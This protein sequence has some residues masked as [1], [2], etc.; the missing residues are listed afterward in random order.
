M[1][2]IGFGGKSK[3]KATQVS[4]PKAF[5]LP[6]QEAAAQEMLG[7][8]QR[9]WRGD[10]TSPLARAYQTAMSES[11][12][13]AAS[14][15]RARLAEERGISTPARQ[16][17]AASI[18]ESAVRSIAEVPTMLTQMSHEYLARYT[19]TPPQIGQEMRGKETGK[20]GPSSSLGCCFIF[21]E[22][23]RLERA[24]MDYRDLHFSPSS[25]VAVGYK[26]MSNWLIPLMR[27]YNSV[28]FAVRMLMIEP[29]T[30]YARWF[31]DKNCYGFV[32]LPM[33]CFW[34]L[35]WR[36]YGRLKPRI[37]IQMTPRNREAVFKSVLHSFFLK[38]L[39]R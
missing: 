37:Y 16:R 30:S 38:L 3:K 24:V 9:I 11:A 8:M 25:A 15:E 4:T 19:L 17:L 5:W 18:G 7:E 13:R 23:D 32:F 12:M 21:L 35:F 22:G 6:G 20:T 31:F 29:L 14:M 26:N 10:I 36:L 28:K 1:G 34:T 27:K 2:S 33:A 39:R